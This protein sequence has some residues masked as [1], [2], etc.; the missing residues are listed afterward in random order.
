[1]IK[2]SETIELKKSLAQLKEGVISLSAMLNKTNIGDVYFGINDDG[3]VFGQTI[4]KNTLSEV[5]HEIQ[6]NLKPIPNI[7]NIKD[8]EMDGR[9]IILV[10]AEGN[11]TPYSAYGRFYIRLN[12][13]DV[14]M[15]SSM[16][17]HFFE[18]KEDNYS[19]WENKETEFD[20]DDIDED[21][22]IDFVRTANEK[23]RLNYIYRNSEETLQ[24]LGLLTANRKLNNAGLYLFGKTRPLTIKEANYPTDLR[25]EFGEIKEFKGNIFECI[26]EAISYIQN[27][28]SY[29]SN[30]IGV[31]REETPEIPVRAIREIVVNS[32]AHASYAKLG[33]DFNQYVIFKSSVRIYNPGPILQN[34]NPM[35]FASGKVGSK[36]RNVLIASVL[37]KYGL[38]DSFGTGFDRTFT[39]C[40]QNNIEYK[41]INDEFG[42]TFIFMRNKNFLNDKINDK[43][44]ELDEFILKI[45]SDNKYSTIPDIASKTGKSE[46]TI[47]RHIESMVKN[48]NLER[49]GSRKNGYWNVKIE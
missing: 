38:I 24:K 35:R 20:I 28:I 9:K 4:G 5:A 8:I 46:I 12:D 18:S 31:Q 44:N 19:K 33:S 7:L 43:I 30:I 13:A 47:Y 6:N 34:I 29:K 45:I 2:E 42:F 14:T 25:T 17:Q 23:G 40:A 49:I 39:L 26:R 37:F 21:L 10:H 41:Y 36:I 15:E 27:H 32:F 16:L 1:M 11:D 3:K 48:N 22:L